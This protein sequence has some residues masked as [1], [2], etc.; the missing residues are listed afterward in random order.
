MRHDKVGSVAA[1]G[2]KTQ[3]SVMTMVVALLIIGFFIA[4]PL[5]PTAASAD[6][7]KLIHNSTNTAS[8]KYGTWGSEYTCATCHNRKAGKNIKYVNYSIATPTGKRRV[9]FDR[10]TTTSNGITG[11]FGNDE[12]TDY[13]DGSR[14]VCEVCHHR[15]LYTITAPA[16]YP[17]LYMRNMDRKGA[18]TGEIV[19]DAIST[20]QATR[21]LR[22][23]SVH[24]VTGYHQPARQPWCT[25]VTPLVS[26]P[27]PMP[28]LTT[29]TA[30]LSKWSAIPAITITVMAFSMAM[31]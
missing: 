6:A 28:V 19:T 21:P 18:V 4:D 13:K 20:A 29:A 8:G 1:T 5:F 26:I 22:S 9:I 12:R 15:T 30:T 7:L 17:I 23:V 14:N 31:T 16:S 25:A 11:V 24:P 2:S 10:Y 27:P 3:A